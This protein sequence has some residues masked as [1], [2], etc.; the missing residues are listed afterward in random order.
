MAISAH[1][2][3][4]YSDRENQQIRQKGKKLI[5]I[6]DRKAEILTLL[7]HKYNVTR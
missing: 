7:M 6:K 4:L 3:E 5:K 1:I 2:F